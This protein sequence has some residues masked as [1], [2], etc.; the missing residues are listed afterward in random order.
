V[1]HF[2]FFFDEKEKEKEKENNSLHALWPNESLA[3][4]TS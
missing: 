3:A 4:V 1:I 2:V